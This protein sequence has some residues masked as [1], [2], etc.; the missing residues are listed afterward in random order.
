MLLRSRTIDNEV[1]VAY[2]QNPPGRILVPS[3]GARA[4]A[5][6]DGLG[7]TEYA[8]RLLHSTWFNARR[9]PRRWRK[10]FVNTMVDREMS[11]MEAA[12]F[13][14]IIDVPLSNKFYYRVRIDINI[15]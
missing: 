14:S 4:D 6:V 15:E 2:R 7:F 9:E 5:V 3:L 10:W 13:W 8:I 12:M 1:M 11:I